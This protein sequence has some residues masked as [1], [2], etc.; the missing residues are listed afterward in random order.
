M[1]NIDIK[2]KNPSN[3]SVSRWLWL[4]FSRKLFRNLKHH[5]LLVLPEKENYGILDLH[6]VTS[7]RPEMS[8]VQAPLNMEFSQTLSDFNIC[9]VREHVLKSGTKDYGWEI[10]LFA[11]WQYV[12]YSRRVCTVYMHLYVTTIIYSLMS[13]RWNFEWIVLKLNSYWYWS[14]SICTLVQMPN[15]RALIK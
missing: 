14:W 11:C 13:V 8:S 5:T 10:N 4:S 2:G 9:S 12:W 7:H 1:Q 3:I 15:D 6:D